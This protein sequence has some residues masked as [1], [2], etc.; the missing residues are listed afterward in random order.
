MNEFKP[1]VISEEERKHRQKKEFADLYE[2]GDVIIIIGKTVYK[3]HTFEVNLSHGDR[4]GDY[5]LEIT[6]QGEPI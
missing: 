1:R 5:K 6:V 2:K 4:D 3:P